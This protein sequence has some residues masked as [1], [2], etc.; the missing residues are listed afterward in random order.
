MANPRIAGYF[1]DPK[2]RNSFE[3]CKKDPQIMMQMIQM[4]PR[5]MDVFKELTG[6]DLM[7]VQ[8]QQMKAKERQED[9]RKKKE[10]ETAKRRAEEEKRRKE[11]EEAALPEEEKQKIARKKQAEAKKAEGNEFYKKR[12]FA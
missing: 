6:I 1:Q 11:E 7:D 5:F 4:D 10:E 3:M 2:F 12:Q 8:A 9:N